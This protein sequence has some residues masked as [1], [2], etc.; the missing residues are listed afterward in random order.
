M[1]DTPMDRAAGRLENI[2]ENSRYFIVS[3]L[4]VFGALIRPDYRNLLFPNA[5]IV[6]R[7]AA[8]VLAFVTVANPLF[9][10]P[11]A[12]FAGWLFNFVFNLCAA[13]AFMVVG[14]VLMIWARDTRSR[15]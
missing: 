13:I 10:S 2:V 14:E 1:S 3:A 15:E 5:T 4:S 8:F 9:E 11:M 12:G 6:M 7:I